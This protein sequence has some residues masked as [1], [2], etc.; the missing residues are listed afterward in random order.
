MYE[1]MQFYPWFLDDDK[2]VN[3]TLGQGLKD[4]I[5][6]PRPASPPVI[7]L[8]KKWELEYGMPVRITYSS[9]L[10]TDIMRTVKWRN[11]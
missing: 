6:W 2:E 9:F 5:C 4:I 11:K 1:C 10:Q 3:F 8:E 7:R